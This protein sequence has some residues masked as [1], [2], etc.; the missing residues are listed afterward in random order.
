MR[1]FDYIVRIKL[2]FCY[3]EWFPAHKYL[4]KNIEAVQRK[5]LKYFVF[6][7]AGVCPVRGTDYSLLLE[8]FNILSLEC[9]RFILSISFLYKLHNNL[10]DCSNLME[11]VQ[12]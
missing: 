3:L 8:R 5:C 9:R 7:C 2:A 10:I 11:N 4:I 12:Y 6:R 1:L